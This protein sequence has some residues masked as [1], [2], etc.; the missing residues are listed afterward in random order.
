[1]ADGITPPLSNPEFA[2]RYDGLYSVRRCHAAE[3]TP[4]DD[5]PRRFL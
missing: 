1:M 3:T 4:K 5:K 2:S